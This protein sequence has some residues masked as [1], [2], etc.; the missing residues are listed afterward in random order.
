MVS[1]KTLVL[2][3][4]LFPAIIRAQATPYVP[5]DDIAY[6]Y[7]DALM[8]RG[9]LQELSALERPFTAGALRAATDSGL[10]RQPSRRSADYLNALRSSLERYELRKRGES[11]TDTLPFRAKA[12]FDIYG[13][14]QTSARREL[15]LADVNDAI[16]PGS[17]GYFVFGARS[18]AGGVR[19]ILDNRLN[20]DPDFHGKQDRSIAGRTQDGYVSGQWKYAHVSFGR[21]ARNWGP[22]SLEGLQLSPAPYTY[23]HLYARFGTDRL[24]VSTVIAK[25]ENLV[26]ND[27][28]DQAARFFSVHRLSYKHGRYEGALSEGVIYSG[29]GRNYEMSLINP[30]NVYALSWRDEQLDGNLSMGF[31]NSWRAGKFGTWGAHIFLD[32]LQIDKCDTTCKEPGSYG[33]TF[34]ADGLPLTGEQ[35][36]FAS[37]TRVSNLAYHTPNPAERYSIREIGLGRPYSDYDEVR[38][39]A[40]LAILARTP[41]K[42]YVAH[43]RQ[44]EGDYRAPFPPVSSYDTTPI[45]LTGTVWTVN[46]I[47]LSGASIVTRDLQIV[48]DAGIN[49]VKNRNNIVGK[50]ITAFE[51]RVKIIWVPRWLITFE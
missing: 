10:A 41:L 22:M 46:R 31:E 26:V 23:D 14:A 44:G 48:G 7:V 9:Y 28:G 42:L 19:A 45:F 8:A 32:D 11:A 3:A 2:S 12:T 43:R 49:N 17:A 30:F 40:D 16:K 20:T 51:G 13:T 21:V 1:L 36:W 4:L 27:D 35:R 25:L 34:T 29:V 5:V 18:L 6:N 15:M 50:N 39:G 38:L 24:N 33:L 37:Y 47:G